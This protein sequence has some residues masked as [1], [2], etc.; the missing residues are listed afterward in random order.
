MVIK[1]DPW[2]LLNIQYHANCHPV[3]KDKLCSIVQE[4]WQNYNV[5]Q[6]AQDE[7]ALLRMLQVSK[8]NN[9]NEL[10]I[11]LD[12][13]AA[14]AP[15]GAFGPSEAAA[16]VDS[17]SIIGGGM[18]NDDELALCSHVEKCT[19][20]NQ[21]WQAQIQ[22]FVYLSAWSSDDAHHAFTGTPPDDLCD[23]DPSRVSK[24]R[25][26]MHLFNTFSKVSKMDFGNIYYV[27]ETA[28]SNFFVT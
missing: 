12:L 7:D 22:E 18:V 27:P 13:S 11:F 9:R 6:A 24:F 16:A 20:L 3:Y 1:N 19:M 14:Q 21:H 10:R 17:D 4:Y 25:T 2:R 8:N 28:L 26:W 15:T 5:V 23:F